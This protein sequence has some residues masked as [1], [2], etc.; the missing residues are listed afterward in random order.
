MAQITDLC[1]R[2]VEELTAIGS[3]ISRLLE[4]GLT[5]RELDRIQKGVNL[6][7]PKSMRE[8]YKW[9]N[10]TKLESN[11]ELFPGWAFDTITASVERYNVLVEPNGDWWRREWF[12]LFSATDVSSIG[13]VC[14]PRRAASEGKIMCFEY[15]LGTL[16]GYESLESMLKTLL[17]GFEKRKIFMSEDGGLDC[18]DKALAR[19]AKKMNPTATFWD[20]KV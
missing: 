17:I 5:D 10:G 11:A 8:M 3:P 16:V 1:E 18:D 7:F 2:I 20:D 6:L 14:S 4:P 19:L 12:P 9:R 13:I 15:M